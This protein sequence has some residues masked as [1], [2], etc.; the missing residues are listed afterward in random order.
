MIDDNELMALILPKD[1]NDAW[2]KEGAQYGTKM[3]QNLQDKNSKN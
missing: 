2:L 3:I 1:A